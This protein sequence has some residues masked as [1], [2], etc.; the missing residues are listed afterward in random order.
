MNPRLFAIA[1]AL[2]CLFTACSRQSAQKNPDARAEDA[3]VQRRN[4]A[5][6][7]G[8]ASESSEGYFHSSPTPPARA[9]A[10]AAGASSAAPIR[11]K[12]TAKDGRSIDA[13]LLAGNAEAVKIRR[14]ADRTE[15]TIPLERLSDADRD[16]IRRITLPP[17]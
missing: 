17:L 16:F 1:T 14:S 7:L 12:L 13:E 8:F 5:E 6:A 10:P 15:F 4:S 11:K 9:A 2:L 3:P